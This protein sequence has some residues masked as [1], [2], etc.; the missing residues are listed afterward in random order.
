MQV[1]RINEIGKR[2]QP[3]QCRREIAHFL[4]YISPYEKGINNFDNEFA[5]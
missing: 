3:T 4:E 5:Q 1:N 2:H